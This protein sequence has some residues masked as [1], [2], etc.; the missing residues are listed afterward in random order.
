MQ[1]NALPVPRRQLYLQLR[2]PRVN[3]LTSSKTIDNLCS[4]C[5][6]VFFYS[7][8]NLPEWDR[9][10]RLRV[11]LVELAL[12]TLLV[13]DASMAA[14]GRLLAHT[15]VPQ[16]RSSDPRLSVT[17]IGRWCDVLLVVCPSSV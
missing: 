8:E 2:L 12:A 16:E 6:F 1:H 7:S 3:A 14:D 10:C 13:I 15:G 11:V 4:F 9:L 17:R 5:L